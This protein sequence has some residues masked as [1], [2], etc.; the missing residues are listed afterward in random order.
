[1][2]GLL[3]ERAVLSEFAVQAATA[4]GDGSRARHGSQAPTTATPGPG[5]IARWGNEVRTRAV[6]M[7][8]V[9]ARSRLDGTAVHASF[10]PSPTTFTPDSLVRPDRSSKDLCGRPGPAAHA[11]MV[12]VAL[13]ACI[14]VVVSVSNHSTSSCAMCDFTP[15]A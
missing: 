14:E 10:T 13:R 1:M 11:A 12:S 15:M 7:P 8:S 2:F 6:L 5:T 4:T 9:Y 3:L